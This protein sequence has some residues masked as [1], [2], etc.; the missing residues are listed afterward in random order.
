M[1]Q[2]ATGVEKGPYL[3]GGLDPKRF[4]GAPS[5]SSGKKG[6]WKKGPQQTQSRGSGV[7]PGSSQGGRDI[8]LLRVELEVDRG[9]RSRFF[10]R[11]LV[12][13]EDQVPP[14]DNRW[15]RWECM[16]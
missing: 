16:L 6:G 12:E 8:G 14:L 2:R 5:S 15:H 9:R 10:S 7:Q 1:V 4:K 3:H 13:G 11:R